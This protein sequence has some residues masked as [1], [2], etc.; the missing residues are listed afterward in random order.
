MSEDITNRALELEER[1]YAAAEEAS[2]DMSQTAALRAAARR[3]CGP[4]WEWEVREAEGG[5]AVF[6]ISRYVGA[7]NL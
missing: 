7:L 3:L 5:G 1:V 2:S 4:E 6:R